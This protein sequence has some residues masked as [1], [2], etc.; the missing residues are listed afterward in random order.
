VNNPLGARLLPNAF[1]R[2]VNEQWSIKLFQWHW[3]GAI[4]NFARDAAPLTT[5]YHWKGLCDSDK[6]FVRSFPFK[7]R[8]DTSKESRYSQ[9]YCGNARS[10]K[11]NL[12]EVQKVGSE[13]HESV[14]SDLRWSSILNL[15]S[16]AKGCLCH[17]ERHLDVVS[18]KSKQWKGIA[19]CR[20][21]CPFDQI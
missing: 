7:K 8:R 14:E 16:K 12:W 9:I 20:S 15:I 4:S 17:Q 10:K 6:L 18:W 2:F 11:W 5:A 1:R 21:R 3:I 19:F 13:C